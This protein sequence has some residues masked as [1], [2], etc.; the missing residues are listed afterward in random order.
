MY[1]Y[2]FN[3]TNN[4]TQAWLFE[5]CDAAR[6]N[7]EMQVR[8]EVGCF[9]ESFAR[10][11]DWRRLGFPFEGASD[12]VMAETLEEFF[13]DRGR[14]SAHGKDIGTEGPDFSGRVQFVAGR[15]R[16]N[17]LGTN[18]P[19]EL[20]VEYERWVA[21]V[22]SLNARAPPGGKV[23]MQSATWTKVVVE[24]G[25]IQSTISAFALS[26]F[27]SLIAVLVITGNPLLTCYTTLTTV[28]LM[29]TLCGSII[30]IM[31][32]EFG[33]IQ[34]VGLTT[35]VG[36]SVDYILHIT[37]AYHTS[38]KRLCRQKT[39]EA[40]TMRGMAVIGGAMTTAGST[41][42]LFPCWN[43]LFYQLGVMLFLNTIIALMFTFFLLCPLLMIGGPTGGCCE[44]YK[45]LGSLHKMPQHLVK[46]TGR[47]TSDLDD[48]EK[49]YLDQ[50]ALP[51]ER[52]AVLGLEDSSPGGADWAR[53]DDNDDVLSLVS[54]AMSM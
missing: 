2:R 44:I 7:W 6:D 54:C 53:E 24:A 18:P 4:E 3:F 23:M 5:V 16:I 12:A 17:V 42:F 29:V 35:L 19:D 34:A 39:N 26:I 37:H 10:H 20:M 30:S 33:A 50:D 47:G 21:L 8:A 31:K 15:M 32:W 46:L 11:L 45:C 13:S 1:D 9:I 43:Y 48:T 28:L 25:I 38:E 36:M 51:E 41:A 27:V 40:L 49:D 22:D 14:E 52:V